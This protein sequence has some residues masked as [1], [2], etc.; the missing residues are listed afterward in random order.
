[1]VVCDSIRLSNGSYLLAEH[2]CRC[3]R[4]LVSLW[5]I[6]EASSTVERARI[7]SVLQS[8]LLTLHQQTAALQH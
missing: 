1:M 5:P 3:S 6:P 7:E 4:V 8:Q 2:C